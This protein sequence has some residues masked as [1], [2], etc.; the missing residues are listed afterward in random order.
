M[1]DTE[2]TEEA[3]Q[4]SITVTLNG[5]SE[6][7]AIPY[8]KKILGK[9]YLTKEINDEIDITEFETQKVPEINVNEKNIEPLNENKIIIL[10]DPT[11]LGKITLKIGSTYYKDSDTNK[12][13]NLGKYKSNYDGNLVMKDEAA[14]E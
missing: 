3:K 2:D 7:F 5:Q 9:I 1:A 11:E 12:Y 10:L 8:L 13:I 4:R 14:A 6:N